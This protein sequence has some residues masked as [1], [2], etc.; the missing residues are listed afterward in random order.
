MERWPMGIAERLA[1]LAWECYE[2]RFDGLRR[3][4]EAAGGQTRQERGWLWVR[5]AH[6]MT[7]GVPQGGDPITVFVQVCFALLGPMWALMPEAQRAM[8][9]VNQQWRERRRSGR[10]QAQSLPEAA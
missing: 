9:L 1:E 4:V 5:A 2:G 3:L 8:R 7:L 10:R 6:G